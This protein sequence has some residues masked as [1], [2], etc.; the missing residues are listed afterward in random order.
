[1]DGQQ[2]SVVDGWKRMARNNYYASLSPR[3]PFRPS[4]KGWESGQISK[5]MGKVGG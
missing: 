4:S 1:M 5:V 3:I 2:D